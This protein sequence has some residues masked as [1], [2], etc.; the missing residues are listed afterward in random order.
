MDELNDYEGAI[1]SIS[2]CAK[3]YKVQFNISHKPV[4]NCVSKYSGKWKVSVMGKVFFNKDFLV[5]TRE[6]IKFVYNSHN[7]DNPVN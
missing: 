7:I 6:A 5:A 1:T 2:A 3:L 4:N